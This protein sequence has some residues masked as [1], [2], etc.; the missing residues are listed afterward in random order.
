MNGYEGR[1][2][3]VWKVIKAVSNIL[4]NLKKSKH[5]ICGHDRQVP[6]I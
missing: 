5:N 4:N 3:N 2:I 1:S 6:D